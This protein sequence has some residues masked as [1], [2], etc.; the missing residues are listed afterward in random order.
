MKFVFL[1]Y[2][3]YFG[4]GFVKRK[5]V[6]LAVIL[7]LSKLVFADSFVDAIQDLAIQTACKGQYSATQAGGGWYDDPHDYYTPQN[8]AERFARM[9]GD[10]TRTTTFYGVCFDYA[11]FAFEDVKSYLNWYREQGLYESQFWIAGVNDDCNVIELVSI[12]T[13]LDYSRKQNGVYIKTYSTSM[14]KVV[15][16]D[17]AT[18]HA[19]L[20]LERADG[21][22]FWVDPTWTDNLG[23]V[24]YGYVENGVEIQCRPDPKFCK[25]YPHFLEDLPLPLEMGSRVPPSKTVNSTD[26][27]QTINDAMP[28]LKIDN[29]SDAILTPFIDVSYI[30]MDRYLG[31]LFSASIPFSWITEKKAS[32][33]NMAFGLEMPLLL[34]GFSFML[35]FE[36]LQNIKDDSAIRG[37]MF[38]LDLARRLFNN[39]AWYIGGGLGMIFDS[40]KE[41]HKPDKKTGYFA[42]KVETGFIFA[43]KRFITKLEVS[44]DNARGFAIGTG[45]GIAWRF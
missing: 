10:K 41:R 22:W 7:L 31:Y 20:W 12:G 25:N 23:Y 17:R 11:Q 40:H 21:I 18:R 33:N 35:G 26:R 13:S 8:M 32:V 16:H 39:M 45:V 36:Y 6:L 38:K 9:S 19:W 37:G 3:V 28:K 5:F 24:V 43:F 27:I 4:G 30:G 1:I 42:W 2:A 14:R 34:H 44:Y 29:I 15:T